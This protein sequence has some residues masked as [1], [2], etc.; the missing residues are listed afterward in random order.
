M[1]ARAFARGDDESGRARALGLRDFD[2]AIG[3]KRRGNTVDRGE[4][5]RGLAFEIA[6]GDGDAQTFDALIEKRSDR[7]H[8]AIGADRIVRIKALHGVVGEREVARGARE[9]PKMIEAC[10]KRKTARARLSRP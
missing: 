1:Q 2:V 5:F 9:R 4:R 8:G 3:A 10:H 6:A 7:L